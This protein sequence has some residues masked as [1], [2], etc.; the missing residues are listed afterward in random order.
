MKRSSNKSIYKQYHNCSQ[1]KFLNF[2]KQELQLRPTG[3]S[4]S[5]SAPRWAR[6]ALRLDVGWHERLC[7]SLSSS[8]RTHADL[9]YASEAAWMEA[10]LTGAAVEEACGRIEEWKR[11]PRTTFKQVKE[12]LIQ[13]K[14]CFSV[15]ITVL[16]YRPGR[17]MTS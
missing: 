9:Y 17:R 12:A 8:L 3:F 2:L 4:V 16:C 13:L 14:N 5:P 10:N 15:T 11:L 6:I 1:Y 7:R